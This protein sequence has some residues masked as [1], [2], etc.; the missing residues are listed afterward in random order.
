MGVKGGRGG[1][2]SYNYLLATFGSKR[3]SS[4]VPLPWAQSWFCCWQTLQ[5]SLVSTF[6]LARMYWQSALIWYLAPSLEI[7]IFSGHIFRRT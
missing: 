2:I 7:K 3:R 6:L 1:G 4:L 5:S